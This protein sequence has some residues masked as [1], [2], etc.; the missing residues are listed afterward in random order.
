[1]LGRC[2]FHRFRDPVLSSVTSRRP[3]IL[4]TGASGFIG[5]ALCR[6]LDADGAAVRGTLQRLGKSAA[7]FEPIGIGPIDGSTDWSNA[8]RGIEVVVHL[9]ARVHVPHQSG[10][11]ALD[12]F[13]HVN[14]KGTLNLARQAQQAGVRRFV[15]LSSIGVNGASTA[16]AAFAAEDPPRPHSPYALSKLEAEE[17]LRCLAEGG[18]LE[19]VIIR[20]PLVYGPGAPGN[21]GA[22]LRWL[23]R[24]WPLPVGLVNK[25]RRSLVALDNLVDL[26]VT[27]SHHPGAANQTFLVCDGE[28][29][30]TRDLLCR[31]AAATGKP[32][33]LLP[34]PPDI[35][36]AVLRTLG[37]S[38]MYQSLCGSL[39]IDMRKTRQVL[40]WTPPVSVDEGLKRAAGLTR[41]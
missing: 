4:V 17:G 15:F 1:V 5:S 25:N 40:D 14:V 21:F 2:T 22:L 32:A 18:G 27:C 6:R 12:A 20:P 19:V 35:L 31:M 16:T 28:D 7:T 26:I 38:E 9:A 30:S 34:V 37:R 29:L 24:G 33:R 41:C 11:D 13:A 39:Q 36:R 8:L 23:Q 3:T 10:R